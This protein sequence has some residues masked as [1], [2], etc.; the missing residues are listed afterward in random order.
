MES[1][2]QCEQ[3]R[4]YCSLCTLDTIHRLLFVTRLIINK[5]N[6]VQLVDFKLENVRILNLSSVVHSLHSKSLND[7]VSIAQRNIKN[8]P[9][10][11]KKAKQANKQR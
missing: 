11:Q 10:P 4:S 7:D 2:E 3:G 8:Q 5:I 9:P 1:Y 6:K